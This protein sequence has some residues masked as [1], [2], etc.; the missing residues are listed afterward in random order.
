MMDTDK[1]EQQQLDKLMQIEDLPDEFGCA[2]IQRN[3]FIGYNNAMHV[4]EL[5]VKNGVLEQTS[6][7][8]RYRAKA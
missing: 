4:L 7:P 1:Q 6:I 2:F 8:Y 3:L 5:G